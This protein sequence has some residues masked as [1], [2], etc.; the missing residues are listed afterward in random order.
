MKTVTSFTI[1]KDSVGDSVAEFHGPMGN[2]YGFF[3]FGE[4]VSDATQKKFALEC[5]RLID[6]LNADKQFRIVAV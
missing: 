6:A 5:S 3:K 2:H 4:N 1:Y